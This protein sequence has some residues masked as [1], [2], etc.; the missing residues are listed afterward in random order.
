MGA[1]RL[2]SNPVEAPRGRRLCGRIIERK[3][4]L[5]DALADVA[6]HDWLRRQALEMALSALYDMIANGD[7]VHPS[8][9]VARSL[10]RWLERH[11]H[12]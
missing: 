11:K 10:N 3:N 7:I 8:E 9:L 4:Q 12:L 6:P 2:D 5:E 1:L